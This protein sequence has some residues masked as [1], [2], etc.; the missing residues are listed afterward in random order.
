M[1][2]DPEIDALIEK[3]RVE[4]DTEKRKEIAFDL[5]RRL[6]KAWYALPLPAVATGF[7]AAWPC[8]GNFRVYQTER[9]N[10][11]LWVDDT[12]APIG[13]A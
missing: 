4:R 11:R 8:L 6:A 5:Q 9:P 2:G 1:S 10:Y 12:K 7:T 13:K 3:G